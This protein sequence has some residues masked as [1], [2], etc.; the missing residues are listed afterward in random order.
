MQHIRHQ[1]NHIQQEYT[2]LRKILNNQKDESIVA[3]WGLM[4]A[5]KSYLL[6]MLTQHLET[7]ISKPTIFV[8]QLKSKQ[9]NLAILPIWIHLD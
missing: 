9:H 6:N 2:E 4:N 5:G 7:S 8:K 3:V 1:L